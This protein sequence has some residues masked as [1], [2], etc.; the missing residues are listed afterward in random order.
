MKLYI[1]MLWEWKLQGSEDAESRIERL[2]WT[3]ISGVDI[4]T[5]EILNP[6]AL[7][8]FQK[9]KDIEFAIENQHIQILEVDPYATLLRSEETIPEKHRKYR[10]EAWDVIS[11]LVENNNG[12]IFYPKERGMLLRD[13]EQKT[14]RTRMTLYKY[15]RRYWQGGQTKNALLPLFDKCGAKGKLRN[16]HGLKRGRPTKLA[17]ATAIPRGVNVDENM[18]DKFRRGISKFYENANGRT[19]Q[20]AY[21]RTLKEYFKKGYELAPDGTLIPYLP[22]ASELPT[23]GQFYYWYEKERNAEQSLSKRKGQRRYNLSY[24]EVLGDS[25]QMAFGP[26]SLYQIDATIGDVYLVSSLDRSRI[27]GRPV[28]YIVIDVFSRLIVGISVSL[29]GPSWLGA[30]QALENTAS[31]K[32]SFCKEYGIEITQE[33]WP[34]CH[35]PEE[36]LADRGELEGYNADNLVNA[37]NVKVS[38]T[39][40][41]R[42]DWKAII[43]R[44]FRLSNDKFIHWIPGAVY[45][46]RERGDTDYR[47]DAVLDLHQFRKLMILSVLDHNKEHRMDW[48]RMDEYMIQAHI[49]PYPID[50][51]NW[52]IHNRVGHLRKVPSEVI[53]LNLLTTTQATVTYRGIRFEGLFYSC[54]LALKEQWFVRARERGTWKIS[55]AYDPRKLD[56]L[57][58]R[59][60]DGRRI[61]ACYLVDADKTFRGLD[62]YEAVDYFELRKQSKEAS[63]TR[64]QQSKATLQAQMEQIINQAT[65]QTSEA[66]EFAE[67]QSKRSRIK[68]IRQNRKQER[69][70]E[71]ETQAWQL[72]QEESV[73]NFGQVIPLKST[74]EEAKDNE[75]EILCEQSEKDVSTN[76]VSETS[77]E[78]DSSHVPQSQLINKLRKLR[79]QTW[80]DDED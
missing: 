55:V 72:G 41:Y 25:T 22:P 80:N 64:K 24:R 56:T 13:A 39:P 34:S 37:L 4:A 8:M 33:D 54:D 51:W 38:N 19:L 32:V 23:F 63:R 3:D 35:L 2:L 73:G 71:R 61:E 43:E 30:M 67:V 48:Y 49:E 7:P 40:P 11:K 76:E 36:I 15:L 75:P 6:K 58:L 78:I 45:R 26:G 16:S 52:G 9:Y 69:E 70:I 46:P 17:K 79:P 68:G 1:N 18:R 62:W 21:D 47:L 14:G 29:E 77:I 12:E 50:L 31:D 60:E 10:D 57:Y 53:K 27:I 59:L 42:A 5:I 74:T 28:I 44:N 20:D 66:S 65:E